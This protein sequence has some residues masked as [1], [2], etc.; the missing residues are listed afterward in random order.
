MVC[1]SLGFFI[2]RSL[3]KGIL[4][5]IMDGATQTAIAHKEMSLRRRQ[6]IKPFMSPDCVAICSNH[7]PITEYLFGDNLEK[8]LSVAKSAAKV[9]RNITQRSNFGS[10]YRQNSSIFHKPQNNFGLSRNLNYQRPPR[11]G[12]NRQF[13]GRPSFRRQ[14]HQ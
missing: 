6:A 4:Q 12:P 5:S 13:R 14:L 7:V 3:V 8:E 11:G 10:G 9:T 1:F 2:F